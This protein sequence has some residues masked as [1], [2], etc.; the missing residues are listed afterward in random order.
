MEVDQTIVKDEELDYWIKEYPN[1]SRD[2]VA[3]ILECV[4]IEGIKDD[5]W[6]NNPN[7]DERVVDKV[8]AANAS[9]SY[10]YHLYYTMNNEAQ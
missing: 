7:L 3:M 6:S 2:E 1:L 8:V 5:Y 4:D 9:A 10:D